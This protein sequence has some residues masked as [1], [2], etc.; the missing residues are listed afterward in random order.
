MPFV[1]LSLLHL[2][3]AGTVPTHPRSNVLP[4]A[5]CDF[6]DF[7]GVY[8]PLVFQ[9]R[10]LTISALAACIVSLSELPMQIT[11]CAEAI[12]DINKAPDDNHGNTSI[13]NYDMPEALD[14][15]NRAMQTSTR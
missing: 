15:L 11:T 10:Q 7:V 2:T 12:N 3:N 5:D 4:R 9:G 8:I 14:S 13:L 6:S 1:V